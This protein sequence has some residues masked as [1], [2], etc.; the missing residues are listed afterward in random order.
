MPVLTLE[1]AKLQLN[2]TAADTSLD[3]ELGAFVASVDE[4]IERHTRKTVAA[5]EFT[6]RIDRGGQAVVLRHRP[7]TAVTSVAMLDGTRSWD[8]ATLD[9]DPAGV[10]RTL[11]GSTFTGPLR[12]TYTAGYADADIPD[13]F[14]LAARIIL[15]HLW[16]T[17]RGTFGSPRM[18]G[19]DDS[20]GSP[21]R[22]AGHGYAIPNAALEL[23]GP[24]PPVIA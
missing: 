20:L 3:G 1:E 10:V 23:L 6:D 19:M 17:Q 14:K 15:Q 16:S 12:V 5:R 9:V 24:Q 8:P 7:V 11:N 13:N 4:V 18:G 22:A 2:V 21:G